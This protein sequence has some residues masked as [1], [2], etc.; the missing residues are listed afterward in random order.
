MCMGAKNCL[1]VRIILLFEWLLAS[2]SNMLLSKHLTSF[3]MHTNTH[4]YIVKYMAN[5]KECMTDGCLEKLHKDYSKDQCLSIVYHSSV[6]VKVLYVS[7]YYSSNCTYMYHYNLTIHNLCTRCWSIL[8][9]YVSEWVSH[10]L[11][12]YTHTRTYTDMHTYI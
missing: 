6:V 2:S 11:N 1:A 10:Y 3:G 5:W 12:T 7:K 4:S 9:C 8:L